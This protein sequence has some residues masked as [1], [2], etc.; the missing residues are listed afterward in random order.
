MHRTLTY[1]LFGLLCRPEAFAGNSVISVD[2]G[3]YQMFL[4]NR[5]DRQIVTIFGQIK[6]SA[7]ALH[8]ISVIA[9]A[10]EPNR[11]VIFDLFSGGGSPLLFNMLFD[12]IR[13]RCKGCLIVA[14][15]RPE[16]A[17]GSACLDIFFRSDLR[18]AGA[19]AIFGFHAE[20][21]RGKIIPGEAE[22]ALI[23][24]GVDRKFVSELSAQ[25]AFSSL[26]PYEVTGEDLYANRVIEAIGDHEP[27]ALDYRRVKQSTLLKRHFRKC[28][29]VL[30]GVKG[31]LDLGA[32]DAVYK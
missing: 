16:A 22:S 7:R 27:S 26:T 4:D 32:I 24:I 25:G 31:P 14:Y 3:S 8:D 12:Q 20:S 9:G 2:G 18:I 29:E 6:F 19:S 11:D 10:I 23:K 1:I 13:G 21:A 17:C 15:V 5:E 28:R 30:L